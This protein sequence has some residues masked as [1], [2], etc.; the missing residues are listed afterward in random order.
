MEF[1][2]FLKSTWVCRHY[3]QWV[4][5]FEN[6]FWGIIKLVYEFGCLHSRSTDGCFLVRWENVPWLTGKHLHLLCLHKKLQNSEQ[7]SLPRIFFYSWETC[8]MFSLI[9]VYFAQSEICY[10]TSNITQSFQEFYQAY[11]SI[12]ISSFIDRTGFI[13]EIIFCTHCSSWPII[14]TQMDKQ[15]NVNK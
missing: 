8:Q 7:K 13:R 12:G 4:L 1:N 6:S 3:P 2:S 5:S 15:Y 14:W 11:K 9:P 10:L